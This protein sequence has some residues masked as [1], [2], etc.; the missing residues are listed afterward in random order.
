MK[1]CA[2]GKCNLDKTEL[3]TL[4]DLLW[5]GIVQT[6][7]D[8]KIKPV[9]VVSESQLKAEAIKWIKEDIEY[10]GKVDNPC[11]LARIMDLYK[12]MKRLN[13]TEEDLK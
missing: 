5:N 12:W 11:K 1:T 8:D 4:K 3:K 2:C 7:D 10:I 13:I 9:K 6:L